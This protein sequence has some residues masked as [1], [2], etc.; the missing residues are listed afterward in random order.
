MR[1]KGRPMYPGKSVNRSLYLSETAV[2]TMKAAADRTEKSESDVAEHC[3]RTTA[4]KLTKKKADAIATAND[5][6]SSSDET[7][8]A[9][10]K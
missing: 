6:A 1:R 5:P 10:T 4:D 7:G 3:I 8:R 2:E 9:T